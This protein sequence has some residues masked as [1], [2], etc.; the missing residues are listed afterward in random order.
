MVKSQSLVKIKTISAKIAKQV[1]IINTHYP[2]DL[3]DYLKRII[4]PKLAAGNIHPIGWILGKNI[5]PC[6]SGQYWLLDTDRGLFFV[7]VANLK[8]RGI[9][10]QLFID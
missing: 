10:E 4:A 1:R 2:N 6:Y 5:D 8:C 7:P 3:L 9:V